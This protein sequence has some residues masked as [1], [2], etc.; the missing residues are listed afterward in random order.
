VGIGNNFKV[1][2]EAVLVPGIAE[3]TG[4]KEDISYVREI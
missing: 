1:N 4:F 3:I 2:Y